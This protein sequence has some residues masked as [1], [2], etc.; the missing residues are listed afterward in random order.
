[1]DLQFTSCQFAFVAHR[2]SFRR[3]SRSH[4]PCEGVSEFCRIVIVDSTRGGKSMPDA[5][6]KTIPLWC[7]VINEAVIKTH[8]HA[9]LSSWEV[10]GRLNTPPACV[11]PSEHE[12]MARLVPGLAKT[13]IESSFDLPCL[14][15]PLRP[16]WITTQ[17]APRSLPTNCLPIVCVSASKQ[18]TDGMERRNNDYSYIQ[19]AA[20]DEE[21]W[22]NVR[23]TS[24]AIVV[25][26]ASSQGLTSAMFWAHY[27]DLLLCSR[28][29]ILN[30]I[31]RIV[32][33]HCVTSDGEQYQA[34]SAVNGQIS[35]STLI[36]LECNAQDLA[37]IQLRRP[38]H[39]HSV[40]AISSE[41]QHLTITAHS[42]KK[43]QLPFLHQVLPAV[44]RLGRQWLNGSGRR[45]I[46]VDETASYDMAVGVLMLL[47]GRF[48]DDN[49][50]ECHRDQP[51]EGA[52][53]SAPCRRMAI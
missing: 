53:F 26:R 20:D 10:H 24:E 34:I 27:M 44:D 32:E 3:V 40:L 42:A 19:G 49:G 17:V 25:Y 43:D 14:E 37:I 5:L 22:S 30:M 46:V 45:L 4:F 48:F 23:I 51:C 39:D 1:M 6:S 29:S 11:S 41:S 31:K 15:K 2:P 8:K 21:S 12:Q 16:F 38:H 36:P 50:E 47:L 18:V 33:S 35:L 28:D 52:A 7:A 9:Q 13:L